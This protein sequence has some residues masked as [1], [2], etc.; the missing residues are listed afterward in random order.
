GDRRNSPWSCRAVRSCASRA[1]GAEACQSA[2]DARAWACPPACAAI[3]RR[4]IC[5][6]HRA[7]YAPTPPSP[8]PSSAVP[9]A[10]R[11]NW[12]DRLLPARWKPYARMAR[13]DRPIGWWLLLLP[14]WWSAALAAMAG[15]RPS[16]DPWH[17]A[18]FFVG[19][20]AMRGA[21]CT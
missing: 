7:T 18:L 2:G 15:G 21:G 16:P 17:L 20:V 3:R 6:G 11:G 13:F 14:C 1:R 5:G 9:D 10:V 19:A 4:F 12:V 8:D